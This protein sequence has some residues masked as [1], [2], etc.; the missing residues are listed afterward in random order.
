MLLLSRYLYLGT[1]ETRFAVFRGQRCRSRAARI[2]IL[3]NDC[4]DCECFFFFG[5]NILRSADRGIPRKP[6]K[7]SRVAGNL[8][9]TI[10]RQQHVAATNRTAP[11]ERFS[12]LPEEDRTAPPGTLSCQNT[13]RIP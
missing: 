8:R 12:P 7:R 2:L 10:K 3:R 11:P 9:L 1:A 5:P 6:G 13:Y 4:E